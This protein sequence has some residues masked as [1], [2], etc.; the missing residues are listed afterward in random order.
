MKEDKQKFNVIG[1]Y[2]EIENSL[3]GKVI[4]SVQLRVSSL[5]INF[6]D[7]SYLD[8]IKDVNDVHLFTPNK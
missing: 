8:V 5:V 4:Q 7:G 1:D 6:S 3:E 2:K